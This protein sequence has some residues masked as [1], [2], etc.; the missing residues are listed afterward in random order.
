MKI[1]FHREQISTISIFRVVERGRS[2]A[3]SRFCDIFDSR[4]LFHFIPSGRIL[5][6]VVTEFASA[7]SLK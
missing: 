4:F 2:V 3:S 1:R 6:M 5:F 7:R